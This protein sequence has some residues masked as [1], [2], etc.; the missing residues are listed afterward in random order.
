MCWKDLCKVYFTKKHVCYTHILPFYMTALQITL[1]GAPCTFCQ[2]QL[3]MAA[4]HAELLT[5]VWKVATM[6]LPGSTT[7]YHGSTWLYMTILHSTMVL[8]GSTWVYYTL[9]WLYLALRDS[10][11]L[12]HGSTPLY[13]MALLHTTWLYYILPWLYLTLHDCTTF[14]HGSNWLYLSRLHSTLA[15]L[16]STWL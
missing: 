3:T 14:Y 11:T 6:A 15:P 16:G 8:L 2:P 4:E 1:Q 5:V 10:T 12:Y 13:T 9:P 7:F